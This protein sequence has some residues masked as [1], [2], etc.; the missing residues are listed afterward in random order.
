ARR[1]SMRE[2]DLITYSRDMWPRLLL[3]VRDGG[4][5]DTPRPHVVVWPESAREVAA[6]VRVARAHGVAIVPY[7]G[8]SGVCGGVVPVRGGITI[9]TKR[10]AE[11][12][13]VSGDEMLCDVDAGINGERFE[14]ELQRRGYT[15]G[16][17]PSSIYCSTVGG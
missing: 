15:F 1:V 16:N 12:R 13:H 7:G 2:S 4:V 5:P 14:R 17:F 9:D 11:L 6:V 8:G 3:A 10:M